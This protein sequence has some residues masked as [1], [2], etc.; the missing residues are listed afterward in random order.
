M[1]GREMAP[2]VLVIFNQQ[3]K[4]IAREYFIDFSHRESSRSYIWTVF[5]AD[6]SPFLLHL[7]EFIIFT[8]STLYNLCSP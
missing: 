5:K 6:H 7:L 1:M 8:E 3:T 2:E 4:I